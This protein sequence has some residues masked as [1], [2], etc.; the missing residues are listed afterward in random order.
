MIQGWLQAAER[1]SSCLGG[2][3]DL[4]WLGRALSRP[5]LFVGRC[6]LVLR[7]LSLHRAAGPRRSPRRWLLDAAAPPLPWSWSNVQ[8]SSRW[9]QLH[10]CGH[11]RP[12][13]P[14]TK[15][16]PWCWPAGAALPQTSRSQPPI[17]YGPV[18]L[19]QDSPKPG[20]PGSL[21]CVTLIGRWVLHPGL[22][23][24]YCRLGQGTSGLGEVATS[25]WIP[26]L[27]L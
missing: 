20:G 14:R 9:G 22:P 2:S 12:C 6:F 17:A 18:Y 8:A 25:S 1:G 21:C 19:V 16:A 15:P 27:R 26:F 11:P 24:A 23:G 13:D 3:G 4:A 10:W 5:L 7:G